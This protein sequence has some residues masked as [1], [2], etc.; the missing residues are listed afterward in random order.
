MSEHQYA[1]RG[2]QIFTKMDLKI[3]YHLIQV[4]NGDEW[5]RAFWCRYR[6]YEFMVMYFSLTNAPAVFPDMMNPILKYLLNEDIVVYIDDIL[7]YPTPEE[8]HDLLVK[9]VLKRVAEN[10]FVISPE[11]CR[12]SS[13]RVEF[14]SYIT[15]QDS[16]EMADDKIG[17][18]K[19]WQRPKSLRDIQSFSALLISTKDSYKTSI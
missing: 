13:E 7:I 2:A 12:C 1:V 19:E 10:D 5:K 14:L 11:K 6:L 17:A 18:I 15:T 4:K 9:E 3:G 8:K 16:R